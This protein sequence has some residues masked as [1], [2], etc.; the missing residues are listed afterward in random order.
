MTMKFS[1]SKIVV[2]SLITL[3]LSQSTAFA[4]WHGGPRDS[5][6]QKSRTAEVQR[7]MEPSA[8]IQSNERMPTSVGNQAL[9]SGP[10]VTSNNEAAKEHAVYDQDSKPKEVVRPPHHQG[11]LEDR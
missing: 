8:G 4:A 3:T 11:G 1:N 9:E 5:Y 2:L 7:P 10:A 6:R